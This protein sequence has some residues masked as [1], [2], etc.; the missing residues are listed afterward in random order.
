[1]KSLEF[2]TIF[3]YKFNRGEAIEHWAVVP[4]FSNSMVSR[5]VI[6]L[7]IR[8][9]PRLHKFLVGNCDH[10]SREAYLAIVWKKF[11]KIGQKIINCKFRK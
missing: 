2:R 8:W 7:L 11:F 4:P 6:D 1:M 10:A 3:L 5:S 9:R